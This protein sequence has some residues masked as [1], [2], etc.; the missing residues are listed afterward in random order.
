MVGT[1]AA[2]EK[3]CAGSHRAAVGRHIAH[4]DAGGHGE[5]PRGELGERTGGR[6]ETLAHRAAVLRMSGALLGG[7]SSGALTGAS[8]ATASSRNAPPIT[9]EKTGAET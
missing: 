5:E 1:P 7:S 9:R 2:G 6:G 3:Q 4:H 8:G